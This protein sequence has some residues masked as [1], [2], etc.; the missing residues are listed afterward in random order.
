MKPAGCGRYCAMCNKTVVDFTL[1]KDGDIIDYL[2]GKSS[3]SVCGLLHAS[4]VGRQLVDTRYR[5]S[6][7]VKIAGKA[8][9][10]FLV[11]Q[12]FCNDLWAQSA[13]KKPA[14]ANSRPVQK[15]R[16]LPRQINGHVMET[17]TGRP[18]AG[19]K[20]YI[21][22]SDAGATTDSQGRFTLT[23]T[24]DLADAG[25]YTVVG[26]KGDNDD[27][28]PVSLSAADVAAGKQ[29]TLYRALRS[30]PAQSVNNTVDILPLAYQ[31]AMHRQGA[32]ISIDA[33]RSAGNLYVIDGVKMDQPVV[34]PSFWHRIK[35]AFSKHK[36]VQ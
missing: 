31:S 18:V 33:A 19:T 26:G 14:V 28:V 11:L 9:A 8:A 15:Q 17:G 32:V 22:G 10:V 27:I 30:G 3:G 16:S 12:T 20:V 1:M 36:K 25:S 23:I 24:H 6:I 4:Q 7:P 21:R 34:R 5:P 13:K 35:Y 29:V 2:H